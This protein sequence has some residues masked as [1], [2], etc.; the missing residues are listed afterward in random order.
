MPNLVNS[1]S[2]IGGSGASAV[3]TW[4][5]T[6][7]EFKIGDKFYGFQYYPANAKL[8]VQEILEPSTITNEYDTGVNVVSIP[9]HRLGDIFTPDDEYYDP[10]NH[11]IYKNW[12]T[13][14][15]ELT[16]SWYTGYEK[17]LIVE[18]A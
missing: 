6:K 5:T 13:S 4:D 17:N 15:A 16:F 3:I 2:S 7:E 1:G 9:K 11:D 12:L 18:V 8:I 10:S 14:Q